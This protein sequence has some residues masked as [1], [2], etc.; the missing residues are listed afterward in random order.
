MKLIIIGEPKGKQSAKFHRIGNFV[1][2]YQPQ[3]VIKNENNIR[4]QIVTQLPKDFVLWT[5][6]VRVKSLLYVFTPLKTLKK[7]FRKVI[8]NGG[9]LY[10]TTKPDLTDNLNKSLFDAMQGVVYENDSLICDTCNVRKV[11]GR[12]PRIEIEMEE[13]DE[14]SF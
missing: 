9:Y 8:D 10:K 1:K 3:D 14:L 6:G 5:K 11:Y 4:A 12:M 7:S 2:S 13:I